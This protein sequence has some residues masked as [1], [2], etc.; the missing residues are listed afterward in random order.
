[1]RWRQQLACGIV[2]TLGASARGDQFSTAA[3]YYAT[4]QWREAVAA[5]DQLV[6]FTPQHPQRTDAE[7]FAPRHSSNC[8]SMSLEQRDLIRSWP[9]IRIIVWRHG[10]VFVAQ[11]VVI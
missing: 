8:M 5:F 7:F 3:G 6:T 9:I 4:G 11:S 2:L 1:M 10:Q